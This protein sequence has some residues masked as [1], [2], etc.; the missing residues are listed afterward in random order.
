MDVKD[1]A[2]RVLSQGAHAI[3]P[4]R[5]LTL[6]DE[7][8]VGF[9]GLYTSGEQD[10]REYGYNL[11]YLRSLDKLVPSVRYRGLTNTCPI[12]TIQFFAH[13][14]DV[15]CHPTESIGDVDGYSPHSMEDFLAFSEQLYKPLFM[16][17]VVTGSHIYA[18]V[19]HKGHTRF[20]AETIN[21]AAE[22]LS[23]QIDKFFEDHCPIAP[24][25]VVE[26]ASAAAIEASF[27]GEDANAVSDRVI[28]RYKLRTPGLGA[29]T[30]R[31]TMEACL[32][33]APRV[34]IAFYSRIDTYTLVRDA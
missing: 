21:K 10:G 32:E 17:F 12:P 27:R 1:Y 2:S 19:H 26:E 5:K 33:V 8:V 13:C 28:A 30:A 7:L 22:R 4:P 16:R 3:S 23:G 9:M 24:A 20:D 15:H 11:V 25:E 14:A 34:G 18:A 6:S 31:V 29:Y